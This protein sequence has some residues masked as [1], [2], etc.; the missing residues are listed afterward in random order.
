MLVFRHIS[1]SKSSLCTIA[2]TQADIRLE[3]V[4]LE[5]ETLSQGEPTLHAV[6]ASG[7][8][9]MGLELEEQQ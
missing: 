5:R 4:Q 3:L 2:K 7:F 1:H 6:S 8:L 9:V